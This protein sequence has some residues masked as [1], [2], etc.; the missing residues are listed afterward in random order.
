MPA[1]VQE[2]LGGGQERKTNRT[3]RKDI[4]G[5]SKIGSYK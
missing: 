1:F 4:D 5:K 3:W 2:A